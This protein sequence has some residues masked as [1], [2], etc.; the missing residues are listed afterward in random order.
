[1]FYDSKYLEDVL[2]NP[3]CAPTGL[4][5]G[6]LCRLSNSQIAIANVGAPNRKGAFSK[7]RLF[8]KKVAKRAGLRNMGMVA[9]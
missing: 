2:L 6:A 4:N 9:I 3:K 1:M 5:F 8:D 7:D